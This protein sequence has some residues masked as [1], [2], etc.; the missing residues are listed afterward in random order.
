[1]KTPRILAGVALASIAL[2]ACGTSSGGA[3]NK[4]TIKIG[5]D[6]P[7]SGAET[8][9]GIPALSGVEFAVHQKSSVDGFT[10]EV[11]NLDDAV[12]GVHDPVKGA[13]NVQQFIDDPK[14]LGMIG[15]F[16]SGVAR[17]QIPKT[18]RASLVQISPANTNPCLT[19]DVY[20]PA[21]V[22]GTTDVTCTAAGVPT[23]EALRP[24]GLTNNYF[25]VA[26]TDDFQGPAV[27]DYLMKK[28][29]DITKVGVASDA[30]AYGK[31]IAD[32][33]SARFT[34]KGGTVVKRQDF[35]N[36]SHVSD[37]RPFLRAAFAAGAQAIYF[38]GTDS[39]NACVV[40][41]QMKSAGF[42]D[43][44][45]FGGGDGIVTGDCLNDAA[46][47]APGMSGSVATVDAT[48][49]PEAKAT[50]DAFRSFDTDPSHFGAYTMPAYDSTN[51]LIQAIHLAIQANSGNMPSR[52]QVLAQMK[53]VDYTGVLG[54]T[55]F[56]DR[57]D[58]TAKIISVYDAKATSS[59][60][61]QTPLET[62]GSYGWYFSSAIDYT[63]GL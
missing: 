59:A 31:G 61:S 21:A 57:G 2:A 62:K 49:R 54:H 27:A 1:M 18:N 29:P 22:T 7:E 47:A 33:F 51:I 3:A 36:A 6:F 58:T 19:K 28:Y 30:E 60:G 16:N 32:S 34:T 24:A 63:N 5:V 20:I 12:N 11:F 50:I 45:P 4:G 42:P 26:T 14:V 43:S 23:P 55:K 9:N 41:N 37:F 10:L 56:D 17:A 40:R 53:N 48:G 38:G 13:Q 35:P 52:A 46:G 44:A 15:P 8:S 25:R 39:N